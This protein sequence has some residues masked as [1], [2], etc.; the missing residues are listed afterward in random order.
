MASC[1][2]LLSN[3]VCQVWGVGPDKGLDKLRKSLKKARKPKA[4]GNLVKAKL[5]RALLFHRSGWPWCSWQSLRTMSGYA[6][7]D[8]KARVAHEN[9]HR[10][11]APSR[12]GRCLLIPALGLTVPGLLRL[13]GQGTF[14]QLPRWKGP[15]LWS[16]AISKGTVTGAK[17]DKHQ[18]AQTEEK[19]RGL[20]TAGK[21]QS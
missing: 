11:A 6:A 18:C 16:S 8:R 3:H 4:G 21:A 2:A 13:W 1:R 12:M 20:T 10:N 15:L 19:Q 14:A 5:R 9:R 7:A 17:Q